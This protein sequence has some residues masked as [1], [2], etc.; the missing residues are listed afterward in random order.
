MHPHYQIILKN[1]IDNHLD[2]TLDIL[3]R[4]IM[5]REENDDIDHDSIREIDKLFQELDIDPIPD[6]DYEVATYTQGYTSLF[7][8]E[9]KE[10]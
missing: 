1:W 4:E 2:L 7:K 8:D 5:I 10:G 9:N 6:E 3:A